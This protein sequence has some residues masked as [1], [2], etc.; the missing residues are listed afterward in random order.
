MLV[1]TIE[2]HAVL[3]NAVAKLLVPLEALLY[4][5]KLLAVFDLLLKQLSG[6]RISKAQKDGVCTASTHL[7]LLLGNVAVQPLQPVELDLLGFGVG[8]EP[9][10]GLEQ[11][12]AG[13]VL[14]PGA[15][16]PL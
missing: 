5:G 13:V 8:R 12:M 10:Q 11:A 1:N 4:V 9:A 14:I 3:H 2:L 16:L 7:L 6:L 15:A